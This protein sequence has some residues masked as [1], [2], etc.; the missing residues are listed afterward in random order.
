MATRGAARHFER[1]AASYSSLRNRGPLG[2][3]RR[4]EQRALYELAAIRH[5]ETVLDVGCGD[6]ETLAWLGARGARAVGVDL[7][8]GMAGIC[9]RRGHVVAVQ[10]MENLGVRPA[11]DWVLCF[12]SLEFTADPMATLAGFGAVLRPGGHL[13]LLYPR[14]STLGR[15]YAAYHRR[16]GVTIQLFRRAEVR[17]GLRAAGLSEPSEWRDCVLSTLCI[18]A[19]PEA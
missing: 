9:R 3:M 16:N 12:G 11:F 18:S 10:D 6:G 2:W 5:G 19:R 7:S 4:Q 1:A 15:L 8:P 14:R 17:A 13:L